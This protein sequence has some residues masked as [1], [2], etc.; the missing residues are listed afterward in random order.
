M[1][2]NSHILTNISKHANLAIP[3]VI[4]HTLNGLHAYL[5]TWMCS[6]PRGTPS[7]QNAHLLMNQ[8]MCS[9]ASAA[10]SM[11]NVHHLVNQISKYVNLDMWSSLRAPPLM[12][13]VHP[14]VAHISAQANPDMLLN[15]IHA[16]PSV[17]KY[18]TDTLISSVLKANA[19]L[20]SK[21]IHL[22]YLKGNVQLL[23]N[24]ISSR[25]NLAMI[26]RMV[27]SAFSANFSQ[28]K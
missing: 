9:S 5:G 15:I 23:L 1:M 3:T 18:L 20:N 17:L 12:S 24:S 22:K 25:A 19:Y 16:L 7:K 6:S 10:H 13:C 28:A 26:I 14:L 2:K 27:L 11:D 21:G 8:I 4:A